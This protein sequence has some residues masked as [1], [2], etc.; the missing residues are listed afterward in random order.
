MS[1]DSSYTIMITFGLI[2]LGGKYETPYPTSY[3]L[4]STTTDLL[5]EWICGGA[6]GVIVIVVG[7][8]YGDTSSNPGRDWLHFT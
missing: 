2:S 6:R 4:N 3:G 1:K 5:Q 7:N 8:E